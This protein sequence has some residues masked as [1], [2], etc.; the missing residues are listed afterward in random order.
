MMLGEAIFPEGPRGALHSAACVVRLGR[1]AGGAPCCSED[2]PGLCI[3]HSL[4][5][6][7]WPISLTQ[8]SWGDF[9]FLGMLNDLVPLFLLQSLG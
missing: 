4:P 1:E 8:L 9:V 5:S 3:I 2:S 7:A 6:P